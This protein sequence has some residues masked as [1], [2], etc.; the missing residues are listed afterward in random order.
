MKFLCQGGA[1]P[2]SSLLS[3]E[4]ALERSR[5]DEGPQ[6]RRK[7]EREA[8]GGLSAVTSTRAQVRRGQVAPL[9]GL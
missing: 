2:D 3:L 5:E 4:Q 7:Q 6:A 1:S 8:D 9:T